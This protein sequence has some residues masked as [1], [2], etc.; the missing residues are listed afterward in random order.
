MQFPCT[1]STVLLLAVIPLFQ[2]I[3]LN[4]CNRTE[5]V[6]YWKYCG[7]DG[8]LAAHWFQTNAVP[9]PHQL[10]STNILVLYCTCITEVMQYSC[11][12][13]TVLLPS[14]KFERG[15]EG[16]GQWEEPNPQSPTATKDAPGGAP[17]KSEGNSGRGCRGPPTS[18]V[19]SERTLQ[20]G[21]GLKN[22]KKREKNDKSQEYQN[23]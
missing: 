19:S 9:A 14:W 17:R 3:D 21:P 11:T 7:I 12:S 22:V 16:V 13:S 15:G 20:W 10:C 1:S 2:S 23:A 6:Q 8:K 18:L 4:N 5:D